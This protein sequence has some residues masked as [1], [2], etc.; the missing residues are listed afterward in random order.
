MGDFVFWVILSLG[1]FATLPYTGC[2]YHKVL[3]VQIIDG[4][5]AQ[6]FRAGRPGHDAGVEGG[7]VELLGLLQ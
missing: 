2:T 1:E 6:I 7:E 5:L 3:H 4:L